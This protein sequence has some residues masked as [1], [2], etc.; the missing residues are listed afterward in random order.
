MA[1]LAEWLEINGFSLSTPGWTHVDLSSLLDRP[2]KRT[3]AKVI[4][5]GPGVIV[6]PLRNT[7]SRRTVPMVIFG[8]L[9]GNGNPHPNA[10]FGCETNIEAIHAAVV[11]APDPTV[12][13]DGTRLARLH[14][15]TGERVARVRVVAPLALGA[16]SA[17]AYRAT[18]DLEFPYGTFV[19]PNLFTGP[20]GGF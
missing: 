17:G 5:G 9:D 1:L 16:F 6:F 4:P 3:G 11:D 7:V 13:P 15:V 12:T 14:L 19:T 2:D 10:R 18:L 20:Y 8:D